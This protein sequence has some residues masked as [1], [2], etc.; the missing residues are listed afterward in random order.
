MFKTLLHPGITLMR[1]LRL[2]PKF[3]LVAAAFLLPIAYLLVTVASDRTETLRFT[4]HEVEGIEVI[5]ELSGLVEPSA[6]WRGSRLGMA[7][8]APGALEAQQKAAGEVE[9]ALD[10]L[11]GALKRPGGDPLGLSAPLH[12][13]RTEWDSVKAA[14]ANHPVD[15]L[16]LGNRWVKAVRLYLEAVAD[17][18]NLSL[19]PDAD[20]YFLMLAHTAQIP[21]A[22]D[23][24]GRIRAVG[25]YLA[26]KQDEADVELYMAFH[27]AGA[28]AEEAF[29]VAQRALGKAGAANPAALKD[30]KTEALERVSSSVLARHDKEFPWG[31]A[32]LAKPDEWFSTYSAAI[33][34]LADLNDQLGIRLEGLLR[35]REARLTLAIWSALGVSLLFV[36]LGIYLLA[37]YY[38]ASSSS[39][40]ALGRRIT[41][42]GR[43]DFTASE[44]MLGKDELAD[45][46]NQLGTAIQDLSHLI[47][48]V[49]A[50]AEEIA[51]AVTQIATGNQDL[52]NRGSE[53]AAVVEQT[54]A[55]TATLEQTVQE[56]LGIAQQADELV[57]RTAGVAGKGGQVV[58][59]AVEAMQEITASSKR[60]GDI[61]QVIDSIAFQ[62]N[63]L[64]LNAAVEAARAGE[65]GR[66]FAVVAGEVRALAQRSASAAREIK[67]L[68]EGSIGS[69]EHGATYVNQAGETMREM[70]SS[71]TTVTQLMGDIK[72]HSAHQADQIRQLASAI[73]EVDSTTQQNAAL[74]EETAAAASS[75]SDRARTL[76][77]STSQFKTD[78]LGREG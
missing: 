11:S 3:S 26:Q 18:S 32:P 61:I 77:E 45:A 49:R 1:R 34:E 22:I 48:Q 5:R 53:M 58:A 35:A 36:A 20:S 74:V 72:R 50:N 24:M 15:G 23:S 25:R 13:L 68:I 12:K 33:K 6:R 16:E 52:S 17:Q 10:K 19:D 44:K 67:G 62:T 76:A 70:V 14:P 71:V 46:G 75:L 41:R 55:S 63:I 7:G 39:F 54:S 57:Q 64:A 47:L 4:Q 69:V 42:M 66:G 27:N 28:L 56:N 31:Q 37:A 78:A 60:I 38:A 9:Q 73:R 51:G 2:A 30:V 29:E 8:N 65:Q 43:G 21:A 40:G 59:K